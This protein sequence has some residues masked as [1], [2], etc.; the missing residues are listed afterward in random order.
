MTALVRS[1]LFESVALIVSANDL[2]K[3]Q[4]ILKQEI[5]DLP[6]SLTT[7]TGVVVPVLAPRCTVQVNHNLDIVVPRPADHSV[8]VVRLSL[9]V[10]LSSGDVVRPVTDRN[11]HVI[12]A[13]SC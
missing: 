10:R 7:V 2:P 8:E 5:D 9:D 3:T 4:K 12:Q 1:T 13:G 6:Q 11:S